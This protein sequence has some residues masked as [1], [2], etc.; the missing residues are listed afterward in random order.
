MRGNSHSY[1]LAISSQMLATK[2]T[3]PEHPV[4]HF[5]VLYPVVGRDS[6]V[7]SVRP[8]DPDVH[9]AEEQQ[10]AEGPL[11][12][13]PPH[14]VSHSPPANPGRDQGVRREDASQVGARQK[15]QGGVRK[16]FPDWTVRKI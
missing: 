5:H 6:V 14:Q 16:I 4:Y 9:R 11:R 10:E 8:R 1:S 7:G 2:K 15:L 12:P 13:V 3:F